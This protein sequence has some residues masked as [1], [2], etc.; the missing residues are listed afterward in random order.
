MALRDQIDFSVIENEAERL[1]IDELETQLGEDAA[2]I[3][4][5]TLLDI[6]TYA[7]NRVKPLYRV[8]LLGRLY[9][10]AGGQTGYAQEITRA[11][12]EAIEKIAGDI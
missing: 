5:D 10:Q 3:D 6:A 9:A 11:V 12:A 4:E 7:L 1:V 2:T 8:T